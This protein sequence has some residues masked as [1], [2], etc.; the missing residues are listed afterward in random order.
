[1]RRGVR[2]VVPLLDVVSNSDDTLL[3]MFPLLKPLSVSHLRSADE[4]Q[5]IMRDLLQVLSI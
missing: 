3:L 5:R 2:N 4:V 1:M